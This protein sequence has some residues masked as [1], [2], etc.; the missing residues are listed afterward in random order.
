MGDWFQT[1]VDVE[2]SPEEAGALADG[3]L[4]WLVS[5]GV[6]AAERTDCVIGAAL[7]HPSGPRAGEVVDASG[8][9]GPWQGGLEVRVGRTVFD[10]GQGD[11]T[12]VTCPH[13]A[14]TVELMNDDFE[15]DRE[16]WEPFRDVVHEWDE[17]YDVVIDCPSCGRP[18]EPAGW[19]WA[20]DYFAFGH[21]GFRFWGWPPLR[22][23]FV[24]GI[25]VRLA[26]HRVVLLDGKL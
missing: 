18:V 23:G 21:L 9:S 16:A 11:P 20:D 22:T 6:V 2:A 13:C 10:G 1:I 12:A 26:G 8:W 25:T 17:G 5:S 14:A 19:R 24:D 4:S 15:L 3:V 7:G